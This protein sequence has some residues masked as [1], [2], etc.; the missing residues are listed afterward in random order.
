MKLSYK[1]IVPILTG[2]IAIG[3]LVHFLWMPKLLSDDQQYF[4]A[5]QNDI[6]KSIIPEINRSLLSGDLATLHMFLD[7]QMQIHK[8]SWGQLQVKDSA[9][10]LIYPFEE[11]SFSVNKNTTEISIAL[12][13]LEEKLGTVFLLTDWSKKK[14]VIETELNL[15]EFYILFI[16]GMIIIIGIIWQNH[17]IRKP[18]L[19]LTEAI[20]ELTKGRSSLEHLKVSND[21]IGQLTHAFQQ[22]IKIRHK[23]EAMLVTK[24]LETEEALKNLTTQQYA[25]D[26]HA[27]V[28]VTNLKGEITYVNTKF[29]EISGYSNEELI[30]K[31]H[32][33]VNSGH[34]DSQFFSEMYHTISQG[35]VWKSEI[36]NKA[37]NGDVYCLDTTIIPFLDNDGKPKNYISI[38]TDIT[39]RKIAEEKIKLAASVFT[40][41]RESITITDTTG[42]IIDVNNTFVTTTG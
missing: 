29:S 20:S 32:R 7:V 37:K 24:Q 31:D 23:N 4:I 39:E 42:S 18:L 27:I 36:F 19:G 13:Y 2:Y 12:S 10:L 33:I 30:G 17:Q 35:D 21:E 40:H 16:F 6:V 11:V 41:A 25:L 22:M 1:L 26:Q 9:G 38:H 8:K 15:L 3:S 5:S 14:L 34:H 28:S